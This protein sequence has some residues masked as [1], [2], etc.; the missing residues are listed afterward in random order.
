[1]T[2]ARVMFVGQ[3][4]SNLPE[5]RF[6]NTFHFSNVVGP[7]Y[8]DVVDD[9]HSIV[10][11][12]YNTQS[13]GG[14]APANFISAYCKRAAQTIA[15]NLEDATPRTP[16]VSPF[17]LAS[18]VGSGLPEE[19]AICLTLT[20]APPI[21]PRRRGR[22]YFGPLA[23]NASVIEGGTTAFPANVANGSADQ[24]SFVLTASALALKVA[25]GLADMPWCIRSTRPSENFVLIEGGW[26]DNV[27][28]TQRRRGPDGPQSKHMWGT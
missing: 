5:D 20:G 22:I 19:V 21:T 7:D 2:N 9:L 26:V 4:A 3:G 11:A 18:A 1:M 16:N 14:N 17:T 13:S 24:I 15:Y 28:D 8:E 12:F 10:Q 25:S 27:F 6:I 23:N